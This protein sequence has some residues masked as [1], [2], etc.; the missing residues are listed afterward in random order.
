VLKNDDADPNWMEGWADCCEACKSDSDCEKEGGS[1]DIAGGV[2][3]GNKSD[4]MYNYLFPV[5]FPKEEENNARQC[6]DKYYDPANTSLCKA[7]EYREIITKRELVTYPYNCFPGECT[8]HTKCTPGGQYE[9]F[10]GTPYVDTKC[11]DCAKCAAGQFDL[12]CDGVKDSICQNH[13]KCSDVGD[14]KAK[15]YKYKEGTTR[16]DTDC[17]Q[18]GDETVWKKYEF[19]LVNDFV[20]T[21]SLFDPVLDQPRQGQA[22][23]ENR[24]PSTSDVN[25]FVDEFT[26][27]MQVK[28]E[29]EDEGC[30]FRISSVSAVDPFF[31]QECR[32]RARG[33][34]FTYHY[35]CMTKVVI[36]IGATGPDNSESPQVKRVKDMVNTNDFTRASKDEKMLYQRTNPFYETTLLQLR[37]LPGSFMPS[38]SRTV[39]ERFDLATNTQKKVSV[40]LDKFDARVAASL[41]QCSDLILSYKSSRLTA[42]QNINDKPAGDKS[43]FQDALK[44]LVNSPWAQNRT[45]TLT[46]LELERYAFEYGLEAAVRDNT[47]CRTSVYEDALVAG[48]DAITDQ[49]SEETFAA[50]SSSSDGSVGGLNF[51]ETI[52]VFIGV[53]VIVVLLAALVMRHK[54]DKAL[55]PSVQHTDTEVVAFENPM[56]ATNKAADSREW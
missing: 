30:D 28:F 2:C 47:T 56:F 11:T 3:G 22:A 46:N 29:K 6:S 35:E 4:P 20:D 51:Q 31:E 45:T 19:V 14:A 48:N 21:I 18:C 27:M 15:Y 43:E 42:L 33:S 36:L 54:G 7:D 5:C 55:P 9:L 10:P 32:T 12:G 1:N 52:G 25:V 38:R 44:A 34:D 53:L 13:K 49:L 17:R 41:K 16:S 8:K 23:I 40:F 26:K 50:K 39:A 37:S 24:Y